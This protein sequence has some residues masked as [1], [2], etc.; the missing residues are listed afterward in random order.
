MEETWTAICLLTDDLPHK[1]K[2]LESTKHLERCVHSAPAKGCRWWLDKWASTLQLHAA[3]EGL[4][5]AGIGRLRL[6]A[7]LEETPC[8]CNKNETNQFHFL[9]KQV[10]SCLLDSLY[11][12]LLL[13]FLFLKVIICMPLGVLNVTFAC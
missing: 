9:N 4:V 7:K 1:R 12:C 3:H 8:T 10:A 2:P 11:I 5:V 6:V 13:I